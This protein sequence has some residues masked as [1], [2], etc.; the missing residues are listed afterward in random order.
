MPLVVYNLTDKE[1]TIYKFPNYVPVPIPI[2]RLQASLIPGT[3]H[4]GINVTDEFRPN[5][6]VDPVNGIIDGLTSKE[7]LSVQSL[8]DHGRVCFSWTS[9]PEYETGPLLVADQREISD[10]KFIESFCRKTE[11]AY[12]IAV[13]KGFYDKQISDGELL[14]MIHGELS[15]AMEAVRTGNPPDN[16]LPNFSS[17]EVELADAIIRIMGM[18]G[19]KNLNVAQAIVEKIRYNSGRQRLH[20]KL[21]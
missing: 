16:H 18:C 21:M 1:L 14:C 13:E 7:L 10:Q 20:G 12:R 4:T 15:E 6:A 5:L 3:K 19:Y 2:V 11:Q 8:V 17:L 9:E